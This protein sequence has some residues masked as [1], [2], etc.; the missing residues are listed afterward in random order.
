VV[1]VVLLLL[2]LLL[3]GS[4]L[5]L[6]AAVRGRRQVHTGAGRATGLAR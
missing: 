2:L 6:G 1:V 5:L 3:Q 4:P